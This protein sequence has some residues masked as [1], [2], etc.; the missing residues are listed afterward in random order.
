MKPSQTEGDLNTLTKQMLSKIL[1]ASPERI[2]IYDVREQR[3]IFSNRSLAKFLGFAPEQKREM[4]TDQFQIIIHPDDAPRLDEHYRI[5]SESKIQGV[6][7]IEYRVKDANDNWHWIHSRSVPF[8]RDEN[9]NVTQILGITSDV[10]KARSADEELRQ[11]RSMLSQV[12]D[13]VPQSIAWKNRDGV[14]MGCNWL[15]SRQVGLA[16]PELIV[17]KTDLDLPWPRKDAEK[18]RSD[19]REIIQNNR[20]RRHINEMMQA[21]DGTR[22]W[23]DK[24]KVPLT[25]EDGEVKG[26]L[27]VF[28]DITERRRTEETIKKEREQLLSIF[29]SMD[30]V[31]YVADPT[32]FELLYVNEAFRRNFGQGIG[33]PCFKI[34]QNRTGSCPFCTNNRIFGQHTGTT[35]IWEFQNEKTKNWFRCI[36][37]AIRWSDDRMVRFEIAIDI[38][39]IKKMNVEL[40]K[41]RANLEQ[42]VHERTKEL[43]TANEQLRIKDNA[44][45]SSTAAFAIIDLDGLLTYVNPAFARIWRYGNESE[46]VGR[47]IVEFVE[48]P[49]YVEKI[50]G[51]M[52][53]KGFWSG[54][55]DGR[56]MD[57]SKFYVDAYVSIVH[58]ESGTPICI[59]SSFVDVTEKK[60]A[61]NALIK[62]ELRYRTL[63]ER[64]PDGVAIYHTKTLLP[65]EYNDKACQQLGYSRDEFSKLTM[66]E[67]EVGVDQER[68][69]E[70]LAYIMD[71]GQATFETVYRTKE[72]RLLDV[73]VTIQ[74]IMIDNQRMAFVLMRDITG[75]K[76]VEA[77]L[78]RRTEEL[79]RSNEEL[80]QFA[81][82]ASHDLQE[83]LRMV[84]SFVKLLQRDYK[85]RLDENADEYIF[86]AVDG[87]NRMYAL[88]NDL[89]DYSRVKTGGKEF[90]QTDMNQV[91]EEALSNL[92]LAIDNTKA[93]ISAEP[94]PT[95]EVDRGQMVE[96]L[97]NLIGNAIKYR[98]PDEQPIID[99]KAQRKTG[100]WI[101]SVQDNGIGIAPQYHERIFGLFQRLHV[102]G[103][104]EGTGIGLAI[105][106]RI[107]ERH[108]G[109]IWVESEPG[110]GS[111][112]SFSIP[113][114]KE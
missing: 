94:L 27:A 83:P 107:V 112:F 105:A 87:V 34:L 37:R 2:F 51:I 114:E 22:F 60:Q 111:S 11:S 64:S 50:T 12:L 74:A 7:E 56:R 18:Y 54:E 85:G 5:I 66:G 42:L 65:V 32:T 58:N 1:I 43:L 80:E 45:R 92:K 4:G 13:S 23:V 86:F 19:D 21:A 93:R 88:I 75:M 79:Q 39:E 106:K 62:A 99:I 26:I 52:R 109:H 35:Y 40:Q 10:T 15:F 101:I 69:N 14:Y 41:H 3:N 70:R 98:K 78:W 97:Q 61:E 47:P 104:Y 68:I 81:Y 55:V 28:D 24:S 48:D 76:L 71:T 82:V 73:L 8:T 6:F 9:G 20:P 33:Q 110:I 95:L 38:T 31:V 89:L 30:E 63:F 90:L 113:V 53:N 49:S 100:D 29:D 57:G 96:L 72:G 44:I 67:I 16:N 103:E 77:S 46:I 84:S 91:L 36:D 108:G 17:G 102:W 59:A 25:S